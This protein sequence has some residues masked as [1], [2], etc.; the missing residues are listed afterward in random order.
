MNALQFTFAMNLYHNSIWINLY[1]AL[2]TEL[3]HP[4]QYH[5]DLM[6]FLSYLELLEQAQR[7][8]GNDSLLTM[9]QL[10]TL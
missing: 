2:I 1:Q 3:S 10:D 4:A 5:D 8:E 9:E 7:E 6:K